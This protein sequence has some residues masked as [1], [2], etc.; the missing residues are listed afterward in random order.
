MKA[1]AVEVQSAFPPGHPAG[2]PTPPPVALALGAGVVG[3]AGLTATY[4]VAGPFSQQTLRNLLLLAGPMSVAAGYPGLP[5]QGLLSR[6]GGFAIQAIS[7]GAIAMQASFVALGT[8][9]LGQAGE[10]GEGRVHRRV[11]QRITE[12]IHT[13]DGPEAGQ[14]HQVHQGDTLLVW[15]RVTEGNLT[16][17]R[18]SW[19]PAHMEVLQPGDAV[20]PGDTV[21]AGSGTVLVER[22]GGI[23]EVIMDP[24]AIQLNGIT[25]LRPGH[26][27]QRLRRQ[28]WFWSAAV[29]AVAFLFTGSPHRAFGVLLAGVPTFMDVVGGA[30]AYFETRK[31]ERKGV[32]PSHPL[33]LVAAGEVDTVLFDEPAPPSPERL[34]ELQH[35]ADKL[36][37]YDYRVGVVTAEQSAALAERIGADLHFSGTPEQRAL[38]VAEQFQRRL[39][40]VVG[41]GA[42]SVP[43]MAT[44]H[45][46]VAAGTQPQAVAAAHVVMTGN[47]DDLPDFLADARQTGRAEQHGET[48]TRTLLVAATVAAAVGLLAATSVVTVTSLL[49]LGMVGLKSFL[50]DGKKGRSAAR[51]RVTAHGNEAVPALPMH[52]S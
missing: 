50:G 9:I 28:A 33:A 49:G 41:S 19:G 11:R 6:A 44:G 1:T 7:V 40:A 35:L 17:D 18:R 37:E 12:L 42:A 8:Y 34:R 36:R 32:L 46:A 3:L 29:A 22:V 48:I 4:A 47:P 39:V 23:D 26:D 30:S 27:P 10:Y 52:R 45:L 5:P 15:G 38:W 16:L 21:L 51:G 13:G 31:W 24:L 2:V 20:R 25:S 14:A 43:A